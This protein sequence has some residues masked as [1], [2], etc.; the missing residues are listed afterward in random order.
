AV[1]GVVGVLRHHLRLAPGRRVRHRGQPVAVVPLVGG[2]GAGGD[3]RLAG[4]V[5]LGV[6]PVGVRAVAGQLVARVGR[7]AG[8]GGAV[9][10]RVVA[11]G[12]G[13]G[14]VGVRDPGELVVGRVGV[15]EVVAGG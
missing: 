7:G 2:R 9:A 13:G 14:T 6:V 3:H 12:L 11:E 15:V 1:E 4:Q 10:D 8:A 5:A